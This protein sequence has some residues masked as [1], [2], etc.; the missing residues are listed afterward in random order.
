MLKVDA[1]LLRAP[2]NKKG[3]IEAEAAPY[4]PDED[5]LKVRAMILKHFIL[6]T[7]NAY[8]PPRCLAGRY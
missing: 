6:G 2:V 3:E 1:V 4:T 7:T 8:T 5:V